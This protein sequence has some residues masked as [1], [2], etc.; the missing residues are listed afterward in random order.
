MFAHARVP[1]ASPRAAWR[2][3]PARSSRAV[4]RASIAEP[5]P[6]AAAAKA[7]DKQTAIVVGGGVG[8]LGMASRLAHAGYDVTILEKNLDTGGR[9]RSESFE[10][11]GEGYRFD[12]GPSLM[13]LPDRYREQ[14]TAVGKN[15]HDYMDIERVDPAYRAHFGD[16]TTLDLLYDTERMRAQLDAVEEG[17]GGRY[18]D[19]LGR[20]RASLD[21]GVAAFIEK[22][23]NSILDF[24]DLRRVGPLAL[25]VNPVDLLLPQFNQMAKYFK[26]EKLRALFSYQELYVGLSPYNAPGVFSLLA[27]TELTDGVWYPI[28]GFDKVR[29]S[30]QKLADEEGVKTRLG[31]EVSKI[32]TEPLPDE[33]GSAIKGSKATQRVT[34]V[35]LESG[36]FLNADVVVANPDL[37]CV[38]EQMIDHETFPEA[39]KEAERWEDAEYSCS[40][41]EFNWCLD[42]TVPDLLHHNVFLSGDYKG[43]WERP[44]VVEDFAAP[45]QHNFYCHNPVYTDKSCAPEGG[46]SVMV[47]LPVANINEQAKICKKRGLPVPSEEDMV[48]AAREAVLRRFKEAG[49]DIE[50][51]IV[52]ESVT[53]PSQWQERFNIKHGAV[54]GLSHGLTQLAAFR[55]PVRTGIPQLDSPEVD[56]LHF[57]GAST[58]PGN[59][60]PLVLMGVKVVFEK[61]MELHGAGVKATKQ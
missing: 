3:S 7:G 58:R 25:A 56:G 51:N 52:S 8:G 5:S 47:L 19:W 41:I 61:I 39:K 10:G 1:A 57:V 50:K 28:G 60:V 13:L 55:P 46:A 2:R 34:G 9:C 53:T 27:A 30:L 17:A 23:A 35:R 21:Y 20:A 42:A 49:K 32:V 29:Q 15:L 31:A 14:F 44:A 37:P 36:E 48:N 11:K 26:N 45:K 38:W 59:G 4:V 6:P 54:F 43:S 18:I 16:H 33:T 12:T 24:V 40:V 22:D